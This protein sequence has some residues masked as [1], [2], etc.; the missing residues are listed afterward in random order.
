MLEVMNSVT[1]KAV[2]RLKNRIAKYIDQPKKIISES[3]IDNNGLPLKATDYI[4]R[5]R[6]IISDPLNILIKRDPRSGTQEGNYIYLHNGNKVLYSDN[7]SYYGSFSD[8]L[9]INRGVHEPLE[10]F[11]FQEVLRHLPQQPVMIELGAYWGHYS[12]WLKKEREMATCFLVEGGKENLNLG[13]HNFLVNGY[14]GLFLQ[15]FVCNGQFEV[16]RFVVEKSI[17]HIDILHSDIQGYEVEMLEGCRKSLGRR[18]ID[19]L[20]ISTH[21]D[22]LHDTVRE[23]LNDEGYDIEV[24]SSFSRESTSYDGLIFASSPNAAKVF[25]SLFTPKGRLDIAKAMPN[26][27]LTY[28]QDVTKA[29]K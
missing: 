22:E 20:F 10:E 26:D 6:E 8:I 15:A 12:M 1:Q 11:L 14:E 18:L 27:L 29:C 13:K 19:Y 5:F 25:N 24:D 9:V 4:G 16:D 23:V 2:A 21:S 28:L 7:Q 17:E 3:S